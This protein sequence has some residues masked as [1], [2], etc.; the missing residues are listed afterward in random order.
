[1]K[2]IALITV[3][4]VLALLVAGVLVTLARA[5]QFRTLAPHLPGPC[6]QVPGVVGG[7]DLTLDPARNGVWVSSDDR[8]A[9]LAGRPVR[10]RLLFV[11]L[12]GHQPEPTDRTPPSPGDFHP[13]GLSL[14]TGPG[15][16][17]RL[18]VINHRSDGTHT[19]ELFDVQP[20]GTLVHADT[21]HDPLFISPNDLAATGPRSFYLGNDHGHASG[22]GWA[23]ETYLGLAG[24]NLLHH[25]GNSASEVASGLAYT[26]G[27]QLSADGR[28]LWV[29]TTTGK[30]L[31]RFARDPATNRLTREQSIE[32]DTGADNIEWD[33][34]GRLLVAGH[35]RML[36]FV[37]HASDAANKAP[38][39]ILRVT[40]G[41]PATIEE[42]LLDD[43]SLLSAASVAVA[44]GG[45]LLLGSVFEPHLLLCQLPEG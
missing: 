23:L 42:L 24:A 9:T 11:A 44:H 32:L 4:A 45:R 5:G 40:P 41:E 21:I 43:G 38:S 14:W 8:R 26:N 7:E 37:G 10:G 25:D 27:M 3:G 33:G 20:T 16:D 31:H 36:D 6:Q 34:Q 17:Q 15:G 1:M 2:R 13:H 18:L 22:L 12:D 39:Q 19:V 28:S 29:A 30:A 35:P